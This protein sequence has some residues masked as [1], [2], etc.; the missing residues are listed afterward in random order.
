MPR[1][2]RGNTL[3]YKRRENTTAQRPMGD[4]GKTTQEQMQNASAHSPKQIQKTSNRNTKTK[5]KISCCIQRNGLVHNILLYS[6]EGLHTRYPVAHKERAP[7]TI[8][9]CIQR[10]DPIH[11]IFL[12]SKEGLHTRYPVAHK[13]RASY[14][15]SCCIQRK[16]LM[17]GV[18]LYSKEGPHTRY[19]V[20]LKR[21]ASYTVS[22]C[23]QTKGLI[24][25]TVSCCIQKKGLMHST[26]LY[27]KEGLLNVLGP[28]AA[29]ECRRP[30]FRC[31]PG[32]SAADE[33]RQPFSRHVPDP[34]CRTNAA[35]P[36]SDMRRDPNIVKGVPSQGQGG[37]CAPNPRKSF[38]KNGPFLRTPRSTT[39]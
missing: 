19:P 3:I 8:S 35:G 31:V 11:G 26:L 17:H 13:G 39:Y 4:H 20:V 9:C 14:T 12:Y 34:P 22:G 15:I 32:P 28:P 10:K 1:E 24:T 36:S 33:R 29:S 7:Y 5:H 16:D 18:L 37:S 30:F 38:E 23:F 2:P 27:S 21:R 6:K 25:Y